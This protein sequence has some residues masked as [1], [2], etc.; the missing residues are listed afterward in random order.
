[1]LINYRDGKVTDENDVVDDN[2]DDGGE[3]DNLETHPLIS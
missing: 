3:D 2:D 1:M